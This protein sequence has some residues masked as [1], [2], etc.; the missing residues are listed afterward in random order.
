MLNVAVRFSWCAFLSKFSYCLDTLARIQNLRSEDEK[1][2]QLSTNFEKINLS[3][4]SVAK[5]QRLS[6][7][8]DIF[9]FFQFWL[10][11]KQTKWHI[12]DSRTFC[13]TQQHF[14]CRFTTFLV[15][16]YR[17]AKK[18]VLFFDTAILFM[19]NHCTS[20]LGVDRFS[21]LSL[22][23]NDW[24]R[25]TYRFFMKFVKVSSRSELLP[26]HQNSSTN[27]MS[28]CFFSFCVKTSRQ[29]GTSVSV[30]AFSP[31]KR[32]FVC[33]SHNVFS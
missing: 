19:L 7:C 3:M 6:N 15:N 27:L 18:Q 32:Q 4:W 12:C 33:C 10:L 29:I 23:V 20:S 25:K 17:V 5:S 21:L 1:R 11:G 26:N 13:S 22:K 28:H 31:L 30:F 24:R 14:V 2:N 8:L 16:H 9:L